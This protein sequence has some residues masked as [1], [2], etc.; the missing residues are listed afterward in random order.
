MS[1]VF[2]VLCALVWGTADYLGGKA[3][4]RAESSVVTLFGQGAGLL[5]ALLVIPIVGDRAPPAAD[6]GYGFLAGGFGAVALMC[7]YQAF[8]TGAMTVVAPIA[9]VSCAL[10]P[11]IWGLVAGD[12]PSGAALAGVAIALVSIALVSGAG[13]RSANPE[14]QRTPLSA[15][16]LALVA[17]L[18]FGSLSVALSYTS[19]EGGLWPVVAMR[20]V[21]LPLTGV[22]VWR[23]ARAA[24]RVR[25]VDDASSRLP[26]RLAGAV[27][28]LALIGGTLDTSANTLYLFSTRHGLLAVVGVI[29]AMYP[30]ATVTLA[31]VRDRERLSALQAT[32]LGLAVAALVLV[33]RG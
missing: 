9:G 30:A 12:R 6:W 28:A 23:S 3:S 18:G 33:A 29:A 22:V 13:A 16:L 19:G 8:A 4:R 2:A 32:G 14:E 10:V 24:G 31:F 17:G 5:A 26:W 7:L 27:L 21:S 20:C 25:S 1:V 11:A 15:H